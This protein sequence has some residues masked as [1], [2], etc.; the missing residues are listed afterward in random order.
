MSGMNQTRTGS[1]N[2]TKTRVAV[3]VQ[4]HS[5]PRREHDTG[6]PLEH[7]QEAGEHVDEITSFNRRAHALR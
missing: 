2:K 6:R 1:T 3:A 7:G 4:H 5:E